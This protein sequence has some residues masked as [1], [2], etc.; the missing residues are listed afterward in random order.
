M[1]GAGEI[2][3]LISQWQRGDKTAED[4][5]FKALYHKLHVMA[6]HYLR[7]ERKGDSL[8]ATALVHEAYL[9]FEQSEGLRILNRTHFLALAA[10]VMRRILVDRARA[11]SAA[12]R[13]AEAASCE[14]AD[15]FGT[16]SQA[17]EVLA[18][19][20]AMESLARQ[21]QRQAQLVELRYFG[22][23][24]EDEAAG[25]L[26]ISVRTVRREWQVARTRLKIA[27][28]GAATA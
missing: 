1:D 22:G 26:G 27:I 2:T 21:S 4:A 14:D 16:D 3:N 17:E 25:I 12:K 6:L 23:F 5:L 20:L 28:D 19:N 10:R 7:G 11:R 15:L 9:R 8:G 13:S 18:V 24:N